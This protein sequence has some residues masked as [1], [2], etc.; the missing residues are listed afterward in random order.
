MYIIIYIYVAYLYSL[1]SLLKPS[2]LIHL[3]MLHQF[4][5]FCARANAMDNNLQ[6]TIFARYPLVI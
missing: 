5:P 6:S 4:H 2:H 1:V 3:C